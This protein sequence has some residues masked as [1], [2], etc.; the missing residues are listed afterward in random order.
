MLPL[1]RL[2]VVAGLGVGAATATQAQPCM[3]EDLFLSSPFPCM[4]SDK[5]FG[6]SP[7]Q[8]TQSAAG[9]VTVPS[10]MV[11]PVPH[12]PGPPLNPGLQ[13]VGPWVAGPGGVIVFMMEDLDVTAGPGFLI[14]DVEGSITGTTTTTDGFIGA[15][16]SF[17]PFLCISS[18]ISCLSSGM[19]DFPPVSTLP[20]DFEFFVLGGSGTA[21]LDSFELDF[22]QV[23]V[24]EPASLAL[25]GTALLGIG[26]IRRRKT[27]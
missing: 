20:M 26:L 21:T 10:I 19:T 14:D 16:S 4:V 6:S 11:M 8:L 23:Q 2:F 18:S 24:P 17:L 15:I 5:T 7:V 22:S 25:L 3:T 13:F 12:S 27:A 9:D 1:I